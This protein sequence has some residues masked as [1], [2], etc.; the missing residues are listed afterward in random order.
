MQGQD[1]PVFTCTSDDFFG[2]TFENED[3]KKEVEG[4]KS[5]AKWGKDIEF[6]FSCIALSV[7]WRN[8]CLRCD[9]HLELF[10]QQKNAKS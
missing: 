2:R 5:R 7:R 1:N 8:S 9:S 3:A 10:S 6:L 4:E